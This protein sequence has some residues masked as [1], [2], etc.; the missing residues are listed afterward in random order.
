M[1]ELIHLSIDQLAPLIKNRNLSPVELTKVVLDHAEASQKKTNA[2]LTFYREEAETKAK[3][4]E[5]EIE[6]GNYRGPF[7]GIPMAIKDNIFFENKRTTMASKIH[8]NYISPYDATV[9]SKLRK[10]GAI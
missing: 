3:Q 10:A 1:K 4:A 7:H 9:I 2:F 8:K 6:G 5:E